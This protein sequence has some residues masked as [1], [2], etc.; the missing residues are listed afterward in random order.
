MSEVY[1]IAREY[2]RALFML[3]EEVG[4][5]ERVREEA[6]AISKLLSANPEYRKMLDTPA[7][8]T[9]ERLSL[10]DGAFGSLDSHL[11]NL[12]KM[13]AK[14]RMAYAIPETLSVYEQEYMEARGIV[15]AEVIS[16]IALSAAQ[17]ARLTEKLGKITGKQIIIE[18]KVD[19][20]ILG[21]MKLRYMGIQRD[22]SVKASLDSFAA[23]LESTVIQ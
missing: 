3:T 10:I 8:S 11:V 4:T 19:P 2:G 14:R 21:G 12:V 1:G 20:S 13:L 22:G 5:T 18:N 6:Q 16:A 9:D 23:A 7:L 17:R 15:R